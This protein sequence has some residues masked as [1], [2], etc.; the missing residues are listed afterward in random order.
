MWHIY[1]VHLDADTCV[2]DQP[3]SSGRRAKPKPAAQAERPKAA[4]TQAS[5]GRR[6]AQAGMERVDRPSKWQ[7]MLRKFGCGSLD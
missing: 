4:S 1:D 6:W 7:R 3:V 5:R 2:A